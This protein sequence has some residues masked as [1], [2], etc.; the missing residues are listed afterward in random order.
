MTK[1]AGSRN[2]AGGSNWCLTSD[3]VRWTR[4]VLALLT[5]A[6]S[7][8]NT[9]YAFAQATPQ[10]TTT[11]ESQALKPAPKVDAAQLDA[12]H[13]AAALVTEFEVNGLKVLVKKRPGSLTVAGGLF[14]RGGSQNITSQN[15]GIESLKL[16]VATEAS[17][18]YQTNR[19]RN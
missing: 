3:F 19:K 5:L 12:E 1:A 16:D 6:W 18:N 11:Q 17:A 2:W 10:P 15:A 4:F 8:G 9:P 13:R 7:V 14:L